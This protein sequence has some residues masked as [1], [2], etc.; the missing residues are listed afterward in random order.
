MTATN[1]ALTG[2]AIGL[3]SG[4]PWVA[5]PAA[6]ISHFICD[7]LPHFGFAE[8]QKILKTSLF[9]NYLIVEAAICFVIVFL[10]FAVHPDH[11]LLAA[12]CAFAAASPDFLWITKFK[13]ARKN[14]KWKPNAF[15]KFAGGIQWFQRPVGALVEIAWFIALVLIIAPF[16]ST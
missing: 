11:W 15:D 9:R 4:N 14:R 3:I 8:R 5:V 16:L 2:A 6:L 7:S 1:H 10:L 13:Q 12:I